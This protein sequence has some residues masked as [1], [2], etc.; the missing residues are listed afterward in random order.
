[1]KKLVLSLS[2]GILS[3]V[4]APIA[5]AT[6]TSTVVIKQMNESPAQLLEMRTIEQPVVLEKH[7]H[8]IVPETTTTE[9]V[10]EPSVYT[11][12]KTSVVTSKECST[13]KKQVRTSY[14][15]HKRV[16]ARHKRHKRTHVASRARSRSKLIAKK[17]VEQPMVVERTE[18]RETRED[19]VYERQQQKSL[20]HMFLPPNAP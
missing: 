5:L 3:L 16:A 10:S 11:S 2:L 15:H 8:I 20:D 12:S 4:A 17:V 18:R 19:V 14:K 9:S 6:D 13:P 7:K 1:M